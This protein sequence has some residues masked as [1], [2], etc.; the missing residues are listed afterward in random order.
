MIQV[1]VVTQPKTVDL[2]TV[3]AFKDELRLT[4]VNS[5]RD[6]WLADR[7]TEAS[8]TIEDELD[9]PLT[10]QRVRQRFPGSD[11]QL[12]SIDVTPIV[13]VERVRSR[14]LGDEDLTITAFGEEVVRIDNREA[15][16]LWHR[17]GWTSEQLQS[18]WLTEDA[19]PG[20]ADR[21]WEATYVGGWLTRADDL[22]ASGV[23]AS[24]SD[25]VV[26]DP[27]SL[28]LLASGDPVTLSGWLLNRGRATIVGVD[29]TTGRITV[30]KALTPETGGASAKLVVKNLPATLERAC[31]DT[32]RAWYYSQ[33]RDTTKS[34]ESLGD[35]SASW[36][37]PE[38][39]SG[40]LPS[41]VMLALN[42]YRRWM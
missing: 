10:R 28:P 32:V 24:G 41:S 26:P 13:A 9:R 3:Q 35:W 6:A 31:L 23:T 36:G 15:G 1:D 38:S 25:F 29:F 21:S 27:T 4:S 33:T 37:G 19:W 39:L 8:R 5:A 7:I 16:L 22:M 11:R 42:R 40:A 30:D 2:T 14:G 34:S 17:D 12:V 18:V 20:S